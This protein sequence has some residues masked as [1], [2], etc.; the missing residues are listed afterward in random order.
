MLLVDLINLFA[1]NSQKKYAKHSMTAFL[2]CLKE[3]YLWNKNKDILDIEQNDI[4]KFIDRLKLKGF[5]NSTIN[6]YIYSLKIFFKFCEKKYK[7]NKNFYYPISEF[8]KAKPTFNFISVSDY[9]AMI[10]NLYNYELTSELENI[11]ILALRDTVLLQLLIETGLIVKELS[12]I[13]IDD[14]DFNGS[15]IKIEEKDRPDRILKLSRGTLYIIENYIKLLGK[16]KFLLYRLDKGYHLTN[17]QLSPRSIQ[18][19]TRMLS[20]GKFSPKD[21]RWTFI[22]S[23]LV[24]HMGLYEVSDLVGGLSDDTKTFLRNELYENEGKF[25]LL[26][27]DY[28]AYEYLRHKYGKNNLLDSIFQGKL[29]TKFGKGLL[30]KYKV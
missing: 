20:D 30:E 11:N 22:I 23:R 18:R 26:S 9:N 8:P 5:K 4:D 6:N 19:V 25:K 14:I 13:K 28:D 2:T 10:D 29:D 12:I 27:G 3:F 15:T 17:L 21:F 1:D 16:R 24:K 7:I